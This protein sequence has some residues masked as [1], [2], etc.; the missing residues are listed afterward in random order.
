L[1]RSTQV[2]RVIAVHRFFSLVSH[3]LSAT[4]LLRHRRNRRCSGLKTS[5]SS[6]HPCEIGAY[7]RRAS[8]QVRIS[9]PSDRLIRMSR[10]IVLL[11]LSARRV[12]VRIVIRYGSIV[13]TSNPSGSRRRGKVM[14]RHT[15]QVVWLSVIGVLFLLGRIEFRDELSSLSIGRGD[16]RVGVPV[17]TGLFEERVGHPAV[18]REVEGLHAFL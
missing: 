6:T 4:V 5:R 8:P 11:T 2:V 9:V 10:V 18:R 17:S 16:G 15:V 14:T 3:I 7:G 1:G 12:T 13:G